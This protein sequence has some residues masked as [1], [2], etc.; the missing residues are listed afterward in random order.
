[1]STRCAAVCSDQ[2]SV[3]LVPHEFVQFPLGFAIDAGMSGVMMKGWQE[4]GLECPP[5]AA[6]RD[7]YVD[8][9]MTADAESTAAEYSR[10]DV[11]YPLLYVIYG[12]AGRAV[13]VSR[14]IGTRKLS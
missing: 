4:A 2:E 5:R 12:S 6:V 10:Y 3:I 9:L 13:V 7:G 8:W 11:H 1:M 14:P